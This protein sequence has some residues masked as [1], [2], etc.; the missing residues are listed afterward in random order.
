MS[1][2]M[3][4]TVTLLRRDITGTD[5]FGN[6]VSGTTEVPITGCDWQP[7]SSVGENLDARQQV[8]AGMV[9]YL[10]GAVGVDA[11]DRF[12]IEGKEYD[13]DGEPGVWSGSLMGSDYTEVVLRRVRG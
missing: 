12:R 6:D 9:L 11:D 2:F 3:T 1:A 5:E 7:R 8:V 13:V 10:P 4:R